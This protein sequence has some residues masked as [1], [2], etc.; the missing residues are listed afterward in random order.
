MHCISVVRSLYFKIFWASFLI[1]FLSPGIAI[2]LLLLLLLLLFTIHISHC[3]VLSNCWL[4]VN[5]V[6]ERVC[7]KTSAPLA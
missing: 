1:T 3:I 7:E 4:L 2:S 6:L 5:S